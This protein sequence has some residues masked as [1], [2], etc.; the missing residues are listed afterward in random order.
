MSPNF[1]EELCKMASQWI[2]TYFEWC[3]R[4]GYREMTHLTV[5]VFVMLVHLPLLLK[6]VALCPCG[7]A[8]ISYQAMPRLTRDHWCLCCSISLSLSLYHIISYHIISIYLSICLSI[9]LSIYL[10]MNLSIYLSIS[11]SLSPCWGPALVNLKF[12]RVG[13]SSHTLRLCRDEFPV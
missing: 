12:L 7:A 9:Y 3:K 6:P 11:L 10:S 2:S 13:I 4:N 1:W 8:W 5:Y